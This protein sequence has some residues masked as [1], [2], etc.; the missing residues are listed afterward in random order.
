MSALEVPVA[1]PAVN[2]NLSGRVAVLTGATG[3]MGS[4]IALELARAGAHVVILARTPARADALGRRIRAQGVEGALEVIAADM[5]RRSD[6]LNAAATIA[7]RHHQVHLVVNNAGAHF[8]DRQL[9]PDGV[10]M[11][12]ALDYLAGYGLTTALAGQL[13]RGHARVVNVASD[14]LNDTRQLK[15]LGPARPATLDLDGVST[16][17]QLNPAAG[18]KAFEAYARAKLMSV[19]AGHALAERLA[20][21]GVTVNAVHPGIVATDIIDDLVPALLKPFSALIRRSMLTPE[22]GAHAAL[23]LATDPAL[24]GVTGRYYNRDM[25]TTT[26]PVA[27]DPTVQQQLLGLS[28]A[29]FGR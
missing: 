4:V 16:L 3:G 14:T 28:D 9:S 21:E 13:R 7:E 22:Q 26:P 18:F 1:A 29:H 10:E 19:T 20:P 11:H 15:L 2:V 25:P 6:V 24:E 8:R 12:I 5:T 23:R 27:Y 17:S